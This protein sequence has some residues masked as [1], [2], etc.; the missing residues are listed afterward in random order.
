MIC[1]GKAG[2]EGAPTYIIV[3]ICS[4]RDEYDKTCLVKKSEYPPLVYTSYISYHHMRDISVK[5]I[6]IAIFGHHIDTQPRL[7]DAVFARVLAGALL[8]PESKPRVKKLLK[9]G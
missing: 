6:D 8:S 4:P 9:S 7:S 2:E 3:P 1:L 5:V